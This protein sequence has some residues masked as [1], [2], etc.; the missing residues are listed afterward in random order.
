MRLLDW[1]KAHPRGL[2]RG[3]VGALTAC[4][5]VFLLGG[6]AP[7]RAA[8]VINPT[9]GSSI[10][11]D[12]NAAA[13]EGTINSAIAFY[14]GTFTNNI[15]VNI[16]FNEMTSGL[17][18]SSF[19]LFVVPY[20]STPNSFRPAL[21]A[22]PQSADTTT[23]LA[24]LPNQTNQPVTNNTNM[25]LKPANIK[26]LG[27]T[28]FLL[29]ASDGTI[30]LNTHITTP[31]SPGTT[32]QYSLL[33]VVEHE[34]DEILGLGSTLGL[35]LQPPFNTDPTPED[36]YRYDGSGNRTFTTSTSAQA[37]FSLDGTTLLD[38]FNQNGLG[39]YGDWVVHNPA[40]VQDWAGTPGA[41][42]SLA[43]DGG[44]EV[45]ALNVIGY[46]LTAPQVTAVPEPAALAQ[47]AAGALTLFGYG[48]RRWKRRAA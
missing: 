9:F 17:G 41:N 40:Q 29:P 26:A 32:G 24:N 48:W 3:G 8:F 37:Y 38:Q 47:L 15:T 44:I 16:T 39:D 33:A 28:G 18:Q 10:T 23:A 13:I 4:L 19:Q 43:N 34:I 14:E 6:G 2:R 5:A 7:A 22:E 46:T 45:R 11:G 31:G 27:L 30:G 1:L 35:N 21:A 42:P 25:L 36:L 20:N 12:P